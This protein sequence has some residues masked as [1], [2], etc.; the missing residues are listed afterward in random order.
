MTVAPQ[1]YLIPLRLSHAKDKKPVAPPG[2]PFSKTHASV[3]PRARDDSSRP[4]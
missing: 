2:I 1:G 3:R 4:G